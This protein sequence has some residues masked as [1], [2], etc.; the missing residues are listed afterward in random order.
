MPGLG[1]P[2]RGLISSFQER[3]RRVRAKCHY[4]AVQTSSLAALSLRQKPSSGGPTQTHAI[5]II[6]RPFR[7]RHQILFCYRSERVQGLT[8]FEIL[9]TAERRTISNY[10]FEF[11]QSKWRSGKYHCLPCSVRPEKRSFHQNLKTLGSSKNGYFAT[12]EFDGQ[13]R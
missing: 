8:Y 4:F 6:K 9:P 13:N 3:A 7:T 12:L 1:R 5:R 11:T 10:T 2:R